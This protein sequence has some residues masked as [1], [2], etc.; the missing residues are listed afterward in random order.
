MFEKKKGFGSRDALEGVLGL[1]SARCRCSGAVGEAT[2]R[3]CWFPTCFLLHLQTPILSPEDAS[4]APNSSPGA[5]MARQMAQWNH[6]DAFRN[7]VGP[8]PLRLWTRYWWGN[9]SR[10]HR[11]SLFA[12]TIGSRLLPY[13]SGY[14]SCFYCYDYYYE[15]PAPPPY[16]YYCFDLSCLIS[17]IQYASHDA[18]SS[19]L[20]SFL[21]SVVLS[22]FIMIISIRNIIII[23][24]IPRGRVSQSN[25]SEKVTLNPQP[26]PTILK[27]LMSLSRPRTQHQ[28]PIEN[29]QKPCSRKARVA[30]TQNT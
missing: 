23:P 8:I 28:A 1:C 4:K 5:C 6:Q 7:V 11:S 14:Y 19:L 16:H 12:A 25:C 21:F 15:F 3:R 26:E 9:W 2:R 24:L 13:V 30:E 22:F 20:P 29:R 17:L 27:N 18:S 10:R